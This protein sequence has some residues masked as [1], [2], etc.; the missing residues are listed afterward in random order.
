MT[1][2]VFRNWSILISRCNTILAASSSDECLE[3]YVPAYACDRTFG[4]RNC[5]NARKREESLNARK[6]ETYDCRFSSA[7][8][9]LK[10]NSLKP[11]T[12]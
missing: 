8:I 11:A 7:Y 12:C 2:D 5:L 3:A 9:A 1:K 4:K 10:V 6:R